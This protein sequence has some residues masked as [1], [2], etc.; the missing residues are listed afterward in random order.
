M[1][2]E[3]WRTS[4][5]PVAMLD[6][7]LPHLSDRKLRLFLVA[8]CR[9]RWESLEP[10]LRE[11]VE[12]SER[13][14]D[15]RAADAER[16]HAVVLARE[17]HDRIQW[18][19]GTSAAADLASGVWIACDRPA[20]LRRTM[21]ARPPRAWATRGLDA[22]AHAT[23]A[24]LGETGHA[25]AVARERAAFAN[26]LRCIVGNPDEYFVLDP[27]WR[28]SAAIGLAEGIDIDRAFD[29]LPILAD[30][31]EEAGCDD[32]HVLGHCRDDDE[33]ARGCWVI[34]MLRDRA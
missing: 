9:R 34:D 17:V 15:G 12:T 32:G 13:F 5:D 22:L 20:D 19:R 30:A 27:R 7:A 8:C 28:T 11:A 29:R 6:F 3:Q 21:V 16:G 2:P 1:T 18:N 31:L 23:E 24:G 26:L 33:H 25:V 10:A 4:I 14:A